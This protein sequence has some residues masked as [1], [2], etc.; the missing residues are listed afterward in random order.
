ML[1]R[2]TYFI[3]IVPYQLNLSKEKFFIFFFFSHATIFRKSTPVNVSL[4]N[5]K[6]PDQNLRHC[7]HVFGYFGILNHFFLDTTSVR[8]HLANSTANS[9]IFA[10]SL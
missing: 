4:V 8:I 5:E 7:L 10:F 6:L 3:E 9:D 2:L 1:D